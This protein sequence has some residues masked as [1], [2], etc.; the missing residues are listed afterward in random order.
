MRHTPSG[1]AVANV[2]LASNRKYKQGDELKEDVC[3]IDVTVFGS[4]AVAVAEHLNKGRKVLVEG[5]LR[6]HAWEAQD[7]QKRSARWTSSPIASTFLPQCRQERQRQASNGADEFDGSI[8]D[9]SD[10][11]PF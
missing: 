5:R 9:D 10:E 11:I 4:T 1:V 8:P 7:G 2:G 3:F 6:Y